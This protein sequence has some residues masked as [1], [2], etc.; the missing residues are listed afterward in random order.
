MNPEEE[1]TCVICEKIIPEETIQRRHY[2]LYSPTKP[3]PPRDEMVCSRKCGN[4]LR[5]RKGLYKEM[6][7][8][9]ADARSQAVSK[10]NRE[11]PRRKVNVK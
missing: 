6:S 11:K 7:D 1:Y 10:S 2:T 4:E 3:I 5:V 9:G 8:A